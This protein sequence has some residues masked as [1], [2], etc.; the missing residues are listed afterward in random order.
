[1]TTSNVSFK[2]TN[3]EKKNADFKAYFTSDSGKYFVI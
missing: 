3:W 2:I 1:M